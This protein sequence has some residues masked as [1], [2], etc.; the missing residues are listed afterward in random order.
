MVKLM[1]QIFNVINYAKTTFIGCI[2]IQ[3]KCVYYDINISMY[4]NIRLI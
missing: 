3:L 2:E 4:S 1:E